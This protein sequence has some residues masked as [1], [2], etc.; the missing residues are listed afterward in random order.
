MFTK[1]IADPFAYNPIDE[2][3][4]ASLLSIKDVEMRRK[5]LTNVLV[6]GGGG[7]L[8]QLPEELIKRLSARFESTE[9]VEEKA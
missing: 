6:V 3:V 7:M 9:G 5:F 8:P 1:E 2:L 4:A